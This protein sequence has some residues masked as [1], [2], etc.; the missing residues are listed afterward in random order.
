MEV[1]GQFHA[2]AA[3]PLEKTLRYSFSRGCVNPRV[4]S[5]AQ[6]KRVISCLSLQRIYTN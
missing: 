4:S 1:S 2:T 6:Q 3:V 5:D